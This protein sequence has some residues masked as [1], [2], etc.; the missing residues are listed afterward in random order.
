[1]LWL[2]NPLRI[3]AYPLWEKENNRCV[4]YTLFGSEKVKC[5]FKFKFHGT[6]K[7]NAHFVLKQKKTR[8]GVCKTLC[9]QQLLVPKYGRIC[10]DVIPQK[11]L[12]FTQMFNR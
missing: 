6:M 4:N 2:S 3:P 12:D 9:P 7:N 11:I 10:S 1:M 5:I 8:A